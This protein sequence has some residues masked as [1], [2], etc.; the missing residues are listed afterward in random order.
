MC[1]IAGEYNINRSVQDITEVLHRMTDIIQH[2]GPDDEGFYIEDGLGLGMRRLSIIDLD[3]GQQPIFNEDKSIV[4]VFNGEIYNYIELQDELKKKGHKFYTDSDTET[5]V[6]LYEEY[7]VECV[8][9]MRG[10]FGFALWDKNQKRLLIVRDRLGVKPLYYAH[11][12]QGVIFGSEIKSLLLH[13]E[14]EARPNLTALSHF[15]SL[16][17]VP[18]P[19]T[20]FEGI[21]ALPPG[22]RL[23][24]TES[25]CQVE[26]YWDIS[27]DEEY[28]KNRTEDDFIEEL[29][30]IIDDSVRLQLRSDVPFGAFLSGGVDSS[31]IVAFMSKYLNEPVKTFSVGFDREGTDQDEL[32]Y[33]RIVAEHYKTDHHEIFVTGQDFI[34]L[35]EKI[36]WHLD[37]PIADQATIANYMV[38][39]LARQHVKMVLTGEGGDELFAGYARYVGERL[40]P[41][42][43]KVPQVV[44]DFGVAASQYLPGLRREKVALYALSHSDEVERITNWFPLLNADMKAQLLSNTLKSQLENESTYSI[45]A[46]HLNATNAQHPLNRMLYVDT[47][48]WLPDDLLARGD[49][50]SMANSL[51][52]RVPLLDHH[53]VE[54]AAKVPPNLKLNGMKR[55]YLLKRV[56]ARYLPDII[57]NR[58]KQ[59][60]PLPIVTWFREEAR[61][62]VGDILSTSKINERGLYNAS[63]V[64]QMLSE[65]N[66]GFAD[67]SLILWGLLNVELWYRN[68][69]D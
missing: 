57:I 36:I 38:S 26:S 66:S 54:F 10:M 11:V 20:M 9:H 40:S 28:G 41:V 19:L 24:C 62:F 58:P 67:N 51:E 18:S 46:K 34:D 12:N 43:N 45:F 21:Q 37:Q 65:H 6:H 8:Q 16:R 4:I 63:Y 29:E 13:P 32:I 68:Y 7:G 1:G 15:L 49:K 3:G 56:S 31:T 35:S 61:E 27:Y 48:L 23:I 42:F 30:S 25:G 44:K 2:R 22:Y 53:L 5:I 39:K 64:E 14:I 50:T 60:F 47:K 33:A 59:G 52:A 69:I 55:K 17:Y